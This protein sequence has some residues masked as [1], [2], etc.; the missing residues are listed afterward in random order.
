MRLLKVCAVLT[1]QH[2][3]EGLG[4]AHALSFI[5]CVMYR[6]LTLLDTGYVKCQGRA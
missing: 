2:C 5:A 6:V 4:T 3:G 1:L